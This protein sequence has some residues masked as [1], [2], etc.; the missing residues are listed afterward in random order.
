MLIIII[1]III[2]I[3]N[4]LFRKQKH[5]KWMKNKYNNIKTTYEIAV[6]LWKRDVWCVVKVSVFLRCFEGARNRCTKG[7]LLYL[8]LRGV[9][10][11]HSKLN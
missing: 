3:I 8:W 2:R 9:L 5:V 7:G 10:L 1:I 6:V 11:N 4:R